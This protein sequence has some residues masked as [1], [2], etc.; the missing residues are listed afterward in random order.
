ML[1]SRASLHALLGAG[2]L[3]FAVAGCTA[4]HDVAEGGFPFPIYEEEEPVEPPK[5]DGDCKEQV[6]AQQDKTPLK[7]ACAGLYSDIKSKKLAKDVLP[8][9]PAYKFWSDGAEKFRYL[10]LPKGEQIDT[11]NPR[12]WKFPVGTQIWKEFRQNG[13]RAE[14]R[15]YKKDRRDHWVSTTYVWDEDERGAER[16]SSG[17]KMPV[18]G[19][20]YE[21]PDVGTCNDCHDGSPDSI[22]GFEMISLGLPNAEGTTLQKLVDEDLLTDAPERTSFEIGDDGTGKAR[23]VLGWLHI[24]CGVTCHNDGVNSKAEETDLRMKLKFEDLD[25]SPVN[26]IEVLKNLIDV[27]AKTTQWQGQKRIVPGKPEESLLYKLITTRLGVDGN[28]QMPPLVTRVV[29]EEHANLIRDWILALKP[30]AAST[31]EGPQ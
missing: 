11:S 15:L 31:T 29:D 10:Q 18:N 13:Q 5:Y 4:S 1:R 26:D 25:G 30:A 7:L 3:A 16:V 21:V 28:K 17:M 9:A 12:G 22:L 6:E 19:Y 20:N 27:P 14:T 8:Y 2:T 23:E 24:N